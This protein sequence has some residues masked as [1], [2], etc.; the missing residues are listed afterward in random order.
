MYLS[1]VI[2]NDSLVNLSCLHKTKPFFHYL[3]NL[4]DT[5]YFPSEVVK[6]YSVHAAIE[7]HREWIL[8]RLKPEQGFYRYC[9]TY[10]S[11]VMAMLQNRKGIDKGEAETY[12]QLKKVKAHFILSDDKAF[13]RALKILDS[14]IRVYTTLHI[15][16]WLEHLKLIPD[17]NSLVKELSR[18]MGFKSKEL[19]EAYL[20]TA[21]QLG[22]TVVKKEMSKKCSLKQIRE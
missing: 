4:F 7:P 12:A 3:N 22:L 6:E 2:D 16:C 20:Q 1:A 8:Q 18:V 10:D 5:V 21:E 11:I 17:W 15:I 9:T 19:R 13:G 14:G